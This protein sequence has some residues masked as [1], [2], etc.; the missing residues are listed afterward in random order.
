MKIRPVAAELF[1]ADGR[2]EG[3]TAVTKLTVALRNFSLARINTMA[4]SVHSWRSVRDDRNDEAY[5]DESKMD[6]A[7]W[8]ST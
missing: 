4:D 6:K 1:Y 5:V 2:T 3:Q 7:S 8:V